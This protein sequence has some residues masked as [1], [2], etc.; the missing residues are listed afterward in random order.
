MRRREF[1]AGLSSAAAWPMAAGAQR[2]MPIIGYLNGQAPTEAGAARDLL[3]FRQG[4]REV[5]YVEDQN[6]VIESRWAEGQYDRLPALAAQLVGRP[7]AVIVATGS[8]FAVRAAKAATTTIP[9]VFS[10][11][12]DPVAAGLV[13]SLNRPGGNLTGVTSL[14]LELSQKKLELMRELVPERPT[15]PFSSTRIIFTPTPY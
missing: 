14:N 6:V 13:V 7:V 11:A 10:T 4:L 3:A 15:W 9:I 8:D 2:Q 5:G 12:A 1:I